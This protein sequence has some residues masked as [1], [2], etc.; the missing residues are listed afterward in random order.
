M[1]K[2]QTMKAKEIDAEDTA[3]EAREL[4]ILYPYTYLNS[5]SKSKF[6]RESCLVISL[7][8]TLVYLYYSSMLRKLA[9]N[10]NYDRICFLL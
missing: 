8:L 3:V 4:W 6:F 10:C 2:V 5:L 9:L 1:E 7:H